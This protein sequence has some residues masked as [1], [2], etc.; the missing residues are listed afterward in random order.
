MIWG[1]F[2]QLFAKHWEREHVALGVGHAELRG[3]STL[4][5][6]LLCLHMASILAALFCTHDISSRSSPQP[7]SSFSSSSLAVSSSSP[8]ILTSLAMVIVVIIIIII[9]DK[10]LSFFLCVFHHHQS[11]FWSSELEKPC[12]T[13]QLLWQ[14]SG[15]LVSHVKLQ[16]C[17]TPDTFRS[18]S[19]IFFDLK[20]ALH[21]RHKYHQIPTVVARLDQINP[22]PLE[23]SPCAADFWIRKP[24]SLKSCAAQ[25][26]AGV[27]AA[28][29][30]RVMLCSLRNFGYSSQS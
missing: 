24:H 27:T 1:L 30:S 8:C 2:R 18:P 10:P 14:L 11:F 4:S 16:L 6:Q 21:R 29:H 3:L 7:F 13:P 26:L 22:G 19:L 9:N 20:V 17:F 25:A 23:H 12:A 5:G 28:R 15:A